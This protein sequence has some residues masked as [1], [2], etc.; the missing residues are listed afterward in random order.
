MTT[1]S[2]GFQPLKM[3][4]YAKVRFDRIRNDLVFVY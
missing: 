4:V 1:A 3:L 2:E